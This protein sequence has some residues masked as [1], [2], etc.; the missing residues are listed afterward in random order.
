M[1]SSLDIVVDFAERFAGAQSKGFATRVEVHRAGRWDDRLSAHDLSLSGFCIIGGVTVQKSEKAS[2]E[3]K[4]P[5]ERRAK[6]QVKQVVVRAFPR[7]SNLHLKRVS[8]ASISS[9]PT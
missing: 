5:L 2:C 1:R 4:A 8:R 7:K 9:A 6:S 3:R